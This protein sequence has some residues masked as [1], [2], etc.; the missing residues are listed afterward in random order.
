MEG[1]MP[2]KWSPDGTAIFSPY[3]NVKTAISRPRNID[4]SQA[5]VTAFLNAELGV[6]HAEWPDKFN[7]TQFE[8]YEMD[9]P[10]QL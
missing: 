10:S 5:Q 3:I 2:Y 1:F 7:G 6:T 8:L 9:N 4:L